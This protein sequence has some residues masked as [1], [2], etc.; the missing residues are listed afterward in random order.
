M[1]RVNDCYSYLGTR[2]NTI[3]PMR[4]A[5]YCNG[6]GKGKAI[7]KQSRTGPE[8]SRSLRLPDVKTIGH[9]GGNVVSPTYRPP[10]PPT[11][12][13]WHSFLFGAWGGVVVKTLR[14]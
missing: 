9:E 10:L 5:I 7:P 12:Y 13:S 3:Q 1:M 4:S 2:I 14:Y 11:K 8:G 6:K